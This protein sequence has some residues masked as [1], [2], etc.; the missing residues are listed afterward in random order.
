[1]IVIKKRVEF[2]FLG[3]EYK[4]AYLVFKSIPSSD[5]D[6]ITKQLKEIEGKQE[7]SLTYILGILKKYFI[8]GKFPDMDKVEADDL[9]GLDPASVIECFKVFTGQQLDPKV[10]TPSTTPSETTTST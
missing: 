6:D 7:G 1:M 10:E 3:E 4:D 8:K 5:F 2:A 9:D